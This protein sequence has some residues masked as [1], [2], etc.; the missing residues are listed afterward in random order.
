MMV[1]VLTAPACAEIRRFTVTPHE[2]CPGTTVKTDWDATGK[3]SVT[4][5]PD[6]KP[7][8]GR[9]YLPTA[10]T[11]FLMTVRGFLK[12]AKAPPN[13]V[14]LY[15]GTPP[16]PVPMSQPLTFTTKCVGNNVV[17]EDTLVPAD[18]DPRLMIATI[19]SGEDREITIAHEGREATFTPANNSST[20]FSGTRLSGSW[21]I[22]VPLSSTEKCSG[23][24][25]PTS[26]HQIA[27]T[28][29]LYC[30]N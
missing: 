16:S 18:W 7:Q 24:N 2:I 9:T 1:V 21:K 20:S 26:L 27:L 6:L 30:R 12:T 4:T 8:S 19:A 11:D 17:A 25:P 23:E 10:D 5:Q 28:P 15:T 3:P 22:T 14:T 29:S 13:R